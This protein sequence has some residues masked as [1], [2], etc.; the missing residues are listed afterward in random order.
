[1][2]K[3]LQHRVITKTKLRFQIFHH[4]ICNNL[5]KRSNQWW[6]PVK[7]SFHTVRMENKKELKLAK[8]VE[9]RDKVWPSGITLRLIISKESL[10]LAKSVERSTGPD[11]HWGSTHAFLDKLKLI[12]SGPDVNWENTI[13][14]VEFGSC[15]WK[16]VLNL[17]NYR[18]LGLEWLWD[19]T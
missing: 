4:G 19:N 7:P 11:W 16:S 9:K 10:F 6:N 2:H 3:H 1:M 18:F 17:T 15:G 5:M 12:K 8:C 14:L 13:V